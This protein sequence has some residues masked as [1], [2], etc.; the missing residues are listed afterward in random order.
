MTRTLAH[1]L[2]LLA[3]RNSWDFELWSAYDANNDLMAQYLPA[4]GFVAFDKNR[5]AIVLNTI[6]NSKKPHLIILSHINLAVIGLLIKLI[7]PKCKIW[8]IAHGIEV[9]RPLSPVKNF[10]LKKCDK[11][12][13]VSNFTKQQ[14]IARHNI[15][16]GKCEILN[17]AIDPFIKL[18]VSF[19]KPA[20][21]LERYKITAGTPV[22]FTLFISANI[23]T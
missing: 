9:W 20:H 2:N 5:I 6:F 19:A 12:I 15:P 10:F 14:V 3:V 11:I 22:I 4:K 23:F 13:C 8:V 7:H 17:N 16:S 18:P 21:L 1:S